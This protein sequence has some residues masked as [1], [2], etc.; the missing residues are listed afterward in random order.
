MGCGSWIPRAVWGDTQAGAP[1]LSVD[2]TY[3]NF[4]ASRDDCLN[5]TLTG[6]IT[7]REAYV[8]RTAT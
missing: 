5:R 3:T 7:S 2:V 8:S 6:Q 1:L 4:S